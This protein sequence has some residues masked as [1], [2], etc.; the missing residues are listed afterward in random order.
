[1]S[2]Q[3]AQPLEMTVQAELHG[4]PVDIHLSLPAEKVEKAL[5]RLHDLGYRPRQA[6][7]GR[8]H[9]PR[10]RPAAKAPEV[11]QFA[12]SGE[13]VCPVHRVPMREGAYGW[14][15]ARKAEPGQPANPKS[16]C[17]CSYKD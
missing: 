7:H 13:P 8:T 2:T 9:P 10:S 6:G 12:A 17:A 5:D 11:E 15:C 4:W 14:Y 16:Y 3:P 1:M